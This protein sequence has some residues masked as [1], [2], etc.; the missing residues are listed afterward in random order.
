[1]N[2]NVR[3]LA[4]RNRIAFTVQLERR[5]RTDWLRFHLTRYVRHAADDIFVITRLETLAVISSDIGILCIYV[6]LRVGKKKRQ[7]KKR[8]LTAAANYYERTLHN[9]GISDNLSVL[10]EKSQ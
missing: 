3:V 5:W 7:V 10:R 1:M 2:E 6:L 4:H 9:R 8:G